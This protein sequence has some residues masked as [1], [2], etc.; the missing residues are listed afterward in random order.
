M[1]I[2]ITI[3]IEN[4][5][6]FIDNLTSISN[7]FLNSLNIPFVISC[8]SSQYNQIK[9]RLGNQLIFDS[10][11]NHPTELLSKNNS[12]FFKRV[13]LAPKKIEWYDQN[14][15]VGTYRSNKQ[16]KTIDIISTFGKYILKIGQTSTYD[17]F[18]VGL[19]RL[20]NFG[21]AVKY[22]DNLF[23]FKGNVDNINTLPYIQYNKN[24]LQNKQQL[25][26]KQVQIKKKKS[27]AIYRVQ[28][29]S[30][31]ANSTTLAN[32]WSRFIKDDIPIELV[33]ENPNLFIVI[34]Q[35]QMLP[36]P[37]RTIYFCMEPYGEKEY[38][39]YINA[40]ERNNNLPLIF[41]GTHDRAMNNVEWHINKT[42]DEL[43]KYSC[44]KTKG[45]A[46]SVI[47]STRNVDPGQKYRLAVVKK[48]DIMASL[49]KLPFEFH[50]Y[51]TCQSLGF[52]NYKGELPRMTK[53]DGLIPYRY[54]FTAENNQ[55][56]NYFT[57]KITDALV[58]ETLVFYNG[59]PNINK[60]FDTNSII[61][62]P[63]NID[64]T[65]NIIIRIIIL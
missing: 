59:C 24:S 18:V 17:D 3:I 32:E 19:L 64:D 41:K 11:E 8:H 58:S 63:D 12:L 42:V 62:V 53:D 46:L 30:N 2:G 5:F 29:F 61:Q 56:E 27:N 49:G 33:D 28:M 34:N 37:D 50:I 26:N 38:L 14:Y 40:L 16:N 20:T 36:P 4:D 6:P 25:Q 44:E 39:Q 10:Y 31:W 52:K 57:E 48:L 35:C 60:Y 13:F 9:N 15:T 7:Y 55:I 51:G 45:K 23:A 21:I 43:E 47:V 65:I 22:D 54:H 1:T